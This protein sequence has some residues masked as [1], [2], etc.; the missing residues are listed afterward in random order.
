MGYRTGAALVFT[1]LCVLRLDQTTRQLTVI[2]TMPGVTREQIHGATGFDVA[3]DAG[4]R[5]VALPSKDTLGVLRNRIDPLGLRRLEFVS[6]KQRGELIAE[7][8]AADRVLVERCLAAQGVSRQPRSR[9]G[10]S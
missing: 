4:C 2:E 3:F 6:A 7:I 1:D 9:R 10:V 8:L 5:E